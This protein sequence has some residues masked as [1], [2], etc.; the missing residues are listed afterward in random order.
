MSNPSHESSLQLLIKLHE[1]DHE[2]AA[3]ERELKQGQD[4]LTAAIDSVAGLKSRLDQLD[5]ELVRARTDANIAEHTADA[6][7]DQLDRLRSKVNQVKTEKQYG[8]ASLEFDLAKQDL[9]RLEDRVLDKMQ[10]VEDLEGRL[11]A[12]R[13]EFDAADAEVAPLGDKL[14]KRRAQMEEELAIKRDR[15]ENLAI[16]LE[17]SARSLYDRI[18]GGR[19]GVALAPLTEESVCGNCNTSVTVQQEMQIK[20]MATLVCCEGCGVILYPGDIKREP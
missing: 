16:R 8:A 19:S 12:L 11:K 1:Y 9:R 4:D 2:I 3:L 13:E 10:M 15:R 6:K 17:A 14:E 18:R 5:A 7:R 20:G